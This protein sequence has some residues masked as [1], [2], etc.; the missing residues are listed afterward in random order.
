MNVL[1]ELDDDVTINYVDNL[2]ISYSIFL[3]GVT[4]MDQY[5]G[6]T[7]IGFTS[8]GLFAQN[9]LAFSYRRFPVRTIT[10]NLNISV[11]WTIYFE[12]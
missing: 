7:S 2:T 3:S 6:E 5:P 4:I 11:I 12:A 10:E 8:I 9:G 1:Y